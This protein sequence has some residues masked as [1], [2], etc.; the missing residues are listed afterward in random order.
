MVMR[1]SSYCMH[2]PQAFKLFCLRSDTDTDVVQ[3]GP[4]S[5]QEQQ[6]Q[7]QPSP[8]PHVSWPQFLVRARWGLLQHGQAVGSVDQLMQVGCV[9]WVSCG[10]TNRCRW[11]PSG[12]SAARPGSG[13]HGPADAGGVRGIGCVGG[14][15]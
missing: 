8:P 2:R 3:P 10:L 7:Q 14:V 15:S 11:G 13:K 9:L 1:H 4:H 5:D 12:L 6:Q